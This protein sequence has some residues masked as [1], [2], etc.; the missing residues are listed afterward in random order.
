MI[1][2]SGGFE[3]VVSSVLKHGQMSVSVISVMAQG[4][5]PRQGSE[6][7]MYSSMNMASKDDRGSSTVDRSE[8]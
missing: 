2:E 1:V 7:C 3:S 4:K 5:V 8:I 6:V